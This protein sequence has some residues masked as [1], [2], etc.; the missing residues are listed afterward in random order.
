MNCPLEEKHGDVLNDIMREWCEMQEQASALA[1]LGAARVPSA[2]LS[3]P[4][5]ALGDPHVKA[6]NF[7]H[8]LSEPAVLALIS[9]PPSEF[10]ETPG[11][12][13]LGPSLLGEHTNEVLNELG[14]STREIA[15]LHERAIV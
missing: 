5:D 7:P 13:H 10:S 14:F 4:P 11:T 15:D 12:I 8:R 9:T 3:L 6:M 2:T 1:A